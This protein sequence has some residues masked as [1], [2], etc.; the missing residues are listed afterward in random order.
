MV[1]AP[2]SAPNRR[3]IARP[4][5]PAS[6]RSPSR[7]TSRPTCSS[8]SKS[9]TE[10][11]DSASARLVCGHAAPSVVRSARP[12]AVRRRQAPPPVAAGARRSSAAQAPSRRSSSRRRSTSSATVDFAV[13]TAAARTVRRA[14]PALAVPALLE[15]VR[16]HM[17]RLRAL[18]RARP[19][20][21][22]QRSAHP[23]RD[24]RGAD[25]HRT[26]ACGPSPTPTSSTTPTRV[27]PA[28]A[29]GARRRGSR[30]SCARR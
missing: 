5:T 3:P 12:A 4:A 9:S 28:A 27:L 24:G 21:R 20:L 8:R 6:I 22:L 26:T 30:S 23:G 7:A 18:P 13:R 16:Q 25:R 19:A 1:C 11:R 14:P 15:A 10:A 2:R 17:R 29:R